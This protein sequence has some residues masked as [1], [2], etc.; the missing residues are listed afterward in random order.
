[1]CK[2]GRRIRVCSSSRILFIHYVTFEKNMNVL[3]GIRM[4][5]HSCSD[6][7]NI[8]F[9]VVLVVNCGTRVTFVEFVAVFI[10]LLTNDPP[11]GKGKT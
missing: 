4:T 2:E 8:L 3:H 5:C 6:D 7:M 1:M 9:L 10:S 11:S